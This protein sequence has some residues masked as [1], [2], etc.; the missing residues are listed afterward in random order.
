[1]GELI[2]CSNLHFLLEY[3]NTKI[4]MIMNKT[5]VIPE[6][7]HYVLELLQL[8]MYRYLYYSHNMHEIIGFFCS[9]PIKISRPTKQYTD[10]RSQYKSFW[11]SKR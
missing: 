10:Y 5:H 9:W 3:D 8:K 7:K 11:K 2:F 1:M 4:I 6:N